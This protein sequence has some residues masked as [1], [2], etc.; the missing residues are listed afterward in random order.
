M[1]QAYGTKENFLRLFNPDKLVHYTNDVDRCFMGSAP[2]FA[3]LTSAYGKE[4][5]ESWLMIQINDF[6][7][8]TN[9]KNIVNAE[10]TERL[11]TFIANDF[12]YIK[13]TE[14]MYFL[15]IYETGYYGKF[16]GNLDTLTFMENFRDFVFKK[17]HTEIDR[18]R[19]EENKRKAED[20][21][22]G[23]ISYEEYLRRHPDRERNE[24]L[25]QLT[26]SNHGKQAHE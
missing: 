13:V 5:T 15:R 17:R 14:F 19:S 11:A 20:I 23:A 18:I 26:N 12:Y 24:I 7:E 9:I 16:Y 25:E 1:I 3:A 6:A 4:V 22:E 10:Q 21:R 8:K 2:T